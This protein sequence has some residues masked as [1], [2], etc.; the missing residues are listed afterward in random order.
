MK[1]YK[2]TT[3]KHTTHGNT[4]WGPGVTHKAT[5]EGT[6]LCSGG[7]LH[8]YTSPLLAVLLNPIH[9]DVS[10]PVLWEAKGEVVASDGLKV[11]CKEL[12]TTVEIP[13]PEISVEQKVRFAI[14]CAS[15]VYK[16]AGWVEWAN[17]WLTGKDRSE[18]AARDVAGAAA[19]AAWAA[20]RAA[21]W[22]VARAAGIAAEID[23]SLI[24][25]WAMSQSNDL[26]ELTGALKS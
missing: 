20:A 12:T 8:A 3:Q 6:K 7:V 21:A 5:G 26:G 15:L 14:G 11:G 9:A 24:I 16:D 19:R 25:T 13:L 4:K 17:N 2:L 23:F 22:A 18:D 1:L 10:D